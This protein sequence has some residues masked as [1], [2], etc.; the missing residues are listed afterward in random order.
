MPAI[1]APS[2]DPYL[3]L[4]WR[5]GLRLYWEHPFVHAARW[6]AF[7]GRHVGAGRL[8]A[9]RDG[10]GHRLVSPRRNFTSMAVAVLGERDPDIMRLLRRRLRPGDTVFDVGA[11]IGTYTLPLAREVG[12]RGR[13]IA[14]EPNRSTRACLRRNIRTNHLRQV[15]I[16]AAAAGPAPGRA[17]LRA[18]SDNLGE[19]HVEPDACGATVVTTLDAE[20]KRLRVEDATF[21][22]LDVEGYELPALRG[23]EVLLARSPRVL[24]QTEVVP[25]HAARFGVTLEDLRD[26]FRARGFRPHCCDAEGRLQE[27]SGAGEDVMDWF[28]QRPGGG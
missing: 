24:V 19:V 15:A 11:N 7:V 1:L 2:P 28:W 17:T 16:V 13:V 27:I 12:P 22:K 4:S 10:H 8:I 6:F 5:R 18:P 20:A 23:A 3:W 25:A 14:F 26:F 9:F 21:L